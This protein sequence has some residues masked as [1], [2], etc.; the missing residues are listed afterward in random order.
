M[1]S[2]DL[3]PKWKRW[4]KPSRL[5]PYLTILGAGGVGVLSWLGAITLSIPEVVI[6]ALLGLLA[7][8]ALIERLDIL[9]RI[10]TKL[11]QITTSQV[12]LKRRLD[13]PSVGEQA[14]NASE[15]CIITIAATTLATYH[16]NFLR[17]RSEMVAKSEL[18]CSILK[19]LLFKPGI[20]KAKY[21]ELR[22]LLEQLWRLSKNLFN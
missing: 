6:I 3:L 7:I 16:R 5:I 22:S 8:D 20:F 12:N 1:E 4:I 19:G 13:L 18:Y 17:E 15:I 11:N 9:E 21:Q 10:D 2:K 14:L